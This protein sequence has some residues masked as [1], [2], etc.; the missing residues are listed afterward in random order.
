MEK[1][2]LIGGN[3]IHNSLKEKVDVSNNH[4]DRLRVVSNLL[5]R[6]ASSTIDGGR[7]TC[8]PSDGTTEASTVLY[9]LEG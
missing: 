7:Y 4:S 5:I 8:S 1:V 3:R 6:D 9:V 2:S